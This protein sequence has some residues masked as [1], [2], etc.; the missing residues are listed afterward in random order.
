MCRGSVVPSPR[1]STTTVRS[2]GGSASQ[3]HPRW[4]LLLHPSLLPSPLVCSLCLPVSSPYLGSPCTADAP[5]SGIVRP[6]DLKQVS[7][8]EGRSERRQISVTVILP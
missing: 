7:G 8:L 2:L 6:R 1:G 5:V 3:R 4:L